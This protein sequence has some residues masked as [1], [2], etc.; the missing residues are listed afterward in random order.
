MKVTR[1]A[2]WRIGTLFAFVSIVG[3]L[4][5]SRPSAL[6]EN[7]FL[8]ELMS[9]DLVAV[10]V[11]VLTITFAS[12]ANVHLSISRL[13]ARATN[14]MAAERAASAARKELNSNAWTIFWAF[15]VALIALFVNGEFPRSE[16]VDALTTAV[17]MTV[18]LLNGLVMHDIYR[19][20]FLL[21]ANEQ[22][23]SQEQ[24][25]TEYNADGTSP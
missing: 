16:M 9:P 10:L 11:I 23:A 15:L 19:S 24:G 6:A 3:S 14:R 1:V 17:C 25:E 21:V 22:A 20:I 7:K 8:D 4:A 18:I 12:V 2:M 13:V 5:V